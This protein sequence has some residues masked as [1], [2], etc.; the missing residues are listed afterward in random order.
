M[1]S[2]R[3]LALIIEQ[4]LDLLSYG[5]HDSAVEQGVQTSQQQSANDN[6][7]E[8]LDTGVHITL[9]ID[10]G[11]GNHS[12]GCGGLELAADVSDKLL[13]RIITST[14]FCVIWMVNRD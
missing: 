14:F 4:A 9:G 5:G 1:G 8:D 11:N 12:A 13:Y 6:S 3:D 10:V 7:D 2:G